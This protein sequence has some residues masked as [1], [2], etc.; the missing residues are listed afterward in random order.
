M[1]RTDRYKFS[2][3]PDATASWNNT[4]SLFENFPTFEVLKKRIL[5]C[6]RPNP[7][8]TFGIHNPL[9]IPYIFQ[10]R[11]GLSHLR[12]H[13]KRHNFIDTPSD[14][15]L[16]KQGKEDTSHFLEHCPFYATQREVLS[17]CVSDIL[18]N[19][20]ITSVNDYVNLYL[21][22]HSL[23]SITDNRAILTATI[24]FIEKTNRFTI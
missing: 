20:Q 15:C 14:M 1:C 17:K 21:Y 4:L 18:N 11:V 19:N 23:L 24:S 10:L 16:C 13:K 9:G 8:T 12:S 2:F 6:I 22:G 7:K 3:F 5:S